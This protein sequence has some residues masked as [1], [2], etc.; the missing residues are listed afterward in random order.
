LHLMAIHLR[1]RQARQL[2][3]QYKFLFV[4]HLNSISSARN[5]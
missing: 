3:Q 5:G 1:D 2:H 4:Q